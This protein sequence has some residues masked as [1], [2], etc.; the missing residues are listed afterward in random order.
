MKPD[1]AHARAQ[2]H[3]NAGLEAMK[4]QRWDHAL[5]AFQ[6][7]VQ[8]APGDARAW[9]H[10]A[11]LQLQLGQPQRAVGA[12]QHAWRLAP[13]DPLACLVLAECFAQQNRHAE[14]A[15]VYAAL[16]ADVPRSAEFLSAHGTELLLAERPQEA[17]PVFIQAVSRQ[18]DNALAHYRM[19]LAF[20]NLHRDNEA[21]V[22]FRTAITVDRQGSVRLLALPQLLSTSM[23][24][25]DWTTLDADVQAL[26]DAIERADDAALGNLAPFSLLA[27]PAG[28]A[29]Q[30][31]VAEG[32][33]RHATRALQPLPPPPVPRRPGRIRVGWL[34]AD[35]HNHATAM[36]VTELLEQRDT[37]RFETFL[38]SHGEDD[39][40]AI[41]TRVRAACEH[42][43][44]V[45][46]LTH[47]E[48]ARRLR[49]DAIDLVIDL[50]G[51]TRQTRFELLAMRPAPVQ[52][53]FL[54]Y[55]GTTGATFID[56][57]IGDAV[58][59]PLSHAAHY[60]ERIAQMPASYQP[61]DSRR[62]LPPA[63]PRAALGLPDDAVVLCCF[64]QS[65][66]FS[67]AMVALW[68]RILHA[69]PHAVLWLLSWNAHGQ[70]HLVAAFEAHGIAAA[71]LVFAPR[72]P[73]DEHLARLQQADLFLDTWPCNAHTTASEALWAGV[74]VLTVPGETFASRVAASLVTA[75]GLPQLAC[76][77]A[78]AYVRDAVALAHDRAALQA[79]QRHLV[80]QRTALPLFDSARHARDF[81]DLLA[82]MHARAQAGLAPD[83]LPGAC[84]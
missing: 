62:P 48:I 65:Y 83:H 73:A 76:A 9:Q 27:L 80:E 39:G 64:N 25:C 35:F 82:R 19:G 28:A 26:F 41:G 18:L 79:L 60:T 8:L 12:A 2:R 54:G 3:W 5:K 75:C 72:R 13:R 42:F 51:H 40:S 38:Y 71:R 22:C 6:Q 55:P 33:T 63:P 1:A 4:G 52:V 29:R 84:A 23:Q 57:V 66:K 43:V 74:P 36:L 77:D 67:P 50:K 20:K 47:A 14:A 69:A 44:D 11:R 68:A 70:R 30:R 81:H 46:T 15:A 56:Y 31:R 7:T 59:T 78:E 58:V 24:A 21:S 32:F 61:N 49:A 34:S 10:V 45:R 53:S 16:P 17:I 37:D